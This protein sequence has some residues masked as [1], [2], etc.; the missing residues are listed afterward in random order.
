M[1]FVGAKNKGNF[2]VATQDFGLKRRLA[3]VGR[4]GVFSFNEMKIE[5]EKPSGKMQDIMRSVLY[6]SLYT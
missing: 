6:N 4:V 2:F 1:V 3:R 5:I